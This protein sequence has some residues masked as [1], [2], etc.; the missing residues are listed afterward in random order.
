VARRE[1]DAGACIGKGENIIKLV[2]EALRE[3]VKK[4]QTKKGLLPKGK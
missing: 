2:A 1:T 3:L 4:Y